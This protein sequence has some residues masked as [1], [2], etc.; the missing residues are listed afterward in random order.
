MKLTRY[1]LSVVLLIAVFSCSVF[2]LDEVPFIEASAYIAVETES[3][4]ILLESNA[5]EHLYPASITKILTA[6]VAVDHL[7]PDDVITVTQEDI[8]GLYEQGSSVFLKKDEEI[9][10]NNLLKYLLVASGNDAANAI[11]RTIA[12]SPEAFAELMNQ[13]ASQ[14]GCTNSHFTNPT[15]LPDDNHWTSARD[16]YLIAMEVIQNPLLVEICSTAKLSLPATNMHNE[17]TFYSTNHLISSYK[18][19]RY[20]YDGATGL[21]TGW[22]G[23][24]GMCLVATATRNDLN[25]MT[26]VLGAPKRADGSQGSFTETTKL[27]NY[28]FSNYKK[29]V[30]IPNTEPICDITVNLAKKGSSNLTLTLSEDYYDILPKDTTREEISIVHLT[31]ADINAPISKGDVLGTASITYDGE[32]RA[33]IDLI[34][35]NDVAR[36]QSAYIIFKIKSFFSSTL[37]KIIVGVL[38]ALIVLILMLRIINVRNRRRRRGGRYRR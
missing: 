16:L 38:L 18:D 37:F 2:A 27:L 26:V 11:A 31:D 15:G 30:F 21:K 7:N 4:T 17:T 23:D 34:A 33:T 22:T 1:C 28:C 32:I 29:D 10:F 24:A 25:I 35:A 5:D 3:N 36:S 19:D 6:L 12:G 9:T 14:L 20:L 13:K 8:D